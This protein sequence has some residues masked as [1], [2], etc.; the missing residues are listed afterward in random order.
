LAGAAYWVAQLGMASINLLKLRDIF[1]KKKVFLSWLNHN[2]GNS[3]FTASAIQFL[4]TK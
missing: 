3:T 4:L 1:S 2:A